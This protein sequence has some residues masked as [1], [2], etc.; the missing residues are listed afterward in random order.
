[1]VNNVLYFLQSVPEGIGIIA[2]SLAYAR[3][4]LRW[5]TIIVGG[6]LLSVLTFFIRSLPVTFGLHLVICIFVIFIIIVKMTNVPGPKAVIAVFASVV[7]LALLEYVVS[8]LVFTFMNLD[9]VTATADEVF[10]T[11][12][13]IIQAILMIIL[14]LVV[15]RF[16]KPQPNGWRE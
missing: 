4:S 10:W 11:K 9:P 8:E 5:K 16:Y 6:I 12:V 1:M 3:V 13:G 2:L 7:T 15:S 14:A